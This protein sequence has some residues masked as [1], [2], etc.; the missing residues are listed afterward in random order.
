MVTY[1]LNF[2]QIMT[3]SDDS[4][5]L[6]KDLPPPKLLLQNP[7]FIG[8]GLI[9][10]Q[11]MG[12]FWLGIRYQIFL[13]YWFLNE[14]AITITFVNCPSHLHGNVS[15]PQITTKIT[16]YKLWQH[17]FSQ[18]SINR[19]NQTTLGTG[20]YT[21]GYSQCQL[22]VSLQLLPF[23]EDFTRLRSNSAANLKLKLKISK[24]TVVSTQTSFLP[25]S[26]CS[27]FVHRWIGWVGAIKVRLVWKRGRNSQF[28]QTVNL[29]TARLPLSNLA[30]HVHT[31]SQIFKPLRET[32]H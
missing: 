30:Q 18:F 8:R 31:C 29:Q 27:S 15:H 9:C 22:R 17:I 6:I 23:W 10:L 19:T 1:T 7:L 11:K 3:Y 2:E 16:V 21:A 28:L 14:L 12:C 24:V 5:H 4:R 32:E 13:F 25:D 26:L 20:S